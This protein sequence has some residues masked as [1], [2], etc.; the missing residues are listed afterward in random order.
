[1]GSAA[2]AAPKTSIGATRC[3]RAPDGPARVRHR[4][5]AKKVR[6]TPVKN[7]DRRPEVEVRFCGRIK[8]ALEL[9]AA[10]G[11][12]NLA[13]QQIFEAAHDLVH[14]FSRGDVGD[15]RPD[16]ISSFDVA[17]HFQVAGIAEEVA[18]TRRC[19]R[20]FRTMKNRALLF[21]KVAGLLEGNHSLIHKDFCGWF[22]I[23]NFDG[24]LGEG[25]GLAPPRVEGAL[26][27]HLVLGFVVCFCCVFVVV[28]LFFGSCRSLRVGRG[29]LAARPGR[30]R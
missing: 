4:R 25:L 7:L 28:R 16:V 22:F 1:M 19:G 3:A 6:R 5:D 2:A 21:A 24:L 10:L 30:W 20:A 8:K 11:H 29:C 9:E 12:E 13:R 27:E 17:V 14:R 23:G 26:A 15:L 18:G